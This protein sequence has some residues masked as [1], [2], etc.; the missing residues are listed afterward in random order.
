MTIPDRRNPKTPVHDERPSGSAPKDEP[1]HGT[2]PIVIKR[3]ADERKPGA[4]NE[5]DSRIDEASEGSFPA[6]DPPA[7]SPAAPTERDRD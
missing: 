2:P 7:I 1:E 5:A 6:S 3:D 4:K